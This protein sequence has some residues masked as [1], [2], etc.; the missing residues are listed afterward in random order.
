[1]GVI[2]FIIAAIFIYFL[3]VEFWLDILLLAIIIGTI[4]VIVTIITKKVQKKR[5][6][7]IK[8]DFRLEIINSDDY[9]R[10]LLILHSLKH[11]RVGRPDCSFYIDKVR[12]THSQFTWERAVFTFSIKDRQVTDF[13]LQAISKLQDLNWIFNNP[14]LL[15]SLQEIGDISNKI[16]RTRREMN[17]E[18]LKLIFDDYAPMPSSFWK[19]II[20]ELTS[21]IEPRC[22]LSGSTLECTLVLNKTYHHAFIK[23]ASYFGVFG[24]LLTCIF[25]EQYQQYGFYMNL[26]PRKR[27]N[28]NP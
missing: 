15:N 9:K 17:V 6:S 7:N 8:N 11:S 19:D 2:A 23:D 26:T 24:D 5:N 3:V 22:T 28:Y 16:N 14:Q 12:E 25:N 10:L 27:E 18:L 1:M 13:C 21:D 20:F 4:L